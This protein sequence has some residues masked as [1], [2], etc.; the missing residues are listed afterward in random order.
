MIETIWNLPPPPGFRGLDPN[1]PLTVYQR[2]LPHWRQDGATY[3]V[4]FRLNDSLPQSKLELL[5]RLKLDWERRN[6]P[7]RSRET[8]E[9]L[10]RQTMQH[11]EGWLDEGMGCCVLKEPDASES[12]AK[13]MQHFDGLRYQLGC[14]VV[15]P[16]HVHAV[17][18]PLDPEQ[19]PLEHILHSW[20]RH[21][22][23]VIRRV[24]DTGKGL[25]QKETYDRIIRDV[26]H[27]WRVIQY[28]ARNPAKAGLSPRECRLWI[29]PAWEV[30]G[31]RFEN[32][33]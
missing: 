25:W 3:F 6:P 18:R 9:R 1:V 22:S 29:N 23:H 19:W 20:K 4:T 11:L 13:A 16:N 7:P 27:L 32:A 17:V 8:L 24:Y 31:W 30:L 28:I 5:H 33:P 15:M 21:S 2:L 14:Y 26:E 10:A 12:V